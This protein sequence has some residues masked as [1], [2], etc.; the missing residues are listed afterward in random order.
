MDF[1][2]NVKLDLSKVE[3]IKALNEF[4]DD[5]RHEENDMMILVI[6]SHGREGS[7]DTVEGQPYPL[8][9][10]FSRFN[11]QQCPNLKGKPKFFIVQVM[12]I[13]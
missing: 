4:A 5:K 10:I 8:E 2:V 1:E 12:Q 13:I 6:L 7:I 11:N 9:N 3:L